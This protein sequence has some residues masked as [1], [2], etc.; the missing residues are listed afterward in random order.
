MKRQITW[1]NTTAEYLRNGARFQSLLGAAAYTVMADPYLDEDGR[2][3]IPVSWSKADGSAFDDASH[4]TWSPPADTKFYREIVTLVPDDET[5]D[6][7]RQLRQAEDLV[8]IVRRK[9]GD[10]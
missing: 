6:L 4:P 5:D 1:H 9:L 7:R 2:R 10:G 8:A 3:Y